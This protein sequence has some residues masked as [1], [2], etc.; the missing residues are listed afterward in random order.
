MIEDVLKQHKEFMMNSYKISYDQLR[1]N[2][3][4]SE[5]LTALERG[6]AQFELDFYLVGAVARDVWMRGI[7][8]KTP[9]RATS[10]VDFAVLINDKGVYE[11]LKQYLIEN[12]GF[13]PSKENAFA[14]LWKDRMEV[15]L[16]PFGQI[17]DD[18]GKVTIQGTGFTTLHVPGFAEVYEEGLP[19]VVLEGA[20]R[21]KFCTLPGIV[22][23]KFIAWSDR[24]EK[25]RDDIKDIS[26]ILHHFFDMHSEEIWNDHNDLFND[27]IELPA[28]AARVMGREMGKIARRNQI[29]SNRIE[30]ILIDATASKNDS[31]IADIMT[32]YYH[33]AI[34]DNVAILINLKLG[35]TE[36][37]KVGKALN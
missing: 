20:H 15:D 2:P 4:I 1:Q 24:P 13:I 17:Q 27:E 11:K 23:L 12:E 35:F 34:E 5:M 32:E 21:F 26:E 7:H 30:S 29:L 16:L 3:G 22:L 25:R 37:R 31:A 6:L 9:L 14:L 8:N 28:I 19:E 33:N 10:D 18:E 36:K